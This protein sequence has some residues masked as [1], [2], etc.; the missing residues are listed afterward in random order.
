MLKVRIY[1][2]LFFFPY[3]F[4]T[5]NPIVHRDYEAETRGERGMGPRVDSPVAISWPLHSPPPGPPLTHFARSLRGPVRMVI[6]VTE[7][8]E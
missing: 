5:F 6:E 2:R 3:L 1:L 4:I 7:G 8:S